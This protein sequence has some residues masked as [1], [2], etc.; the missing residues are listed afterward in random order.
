MRLVNVRILSSWGCCAHLRWTL[1][2]GKPLRCLTFKVPRLEVALRA[3]TAF[4]CALWCMINVS[5]SSSGRVF[6]QRGSIF[7]SNSKTSRS[8]EFGK[9]NLHI[10]NSSLQNTAKFL[11]R[12]R[13]IFGTFENILIFSPRNFDKYFEG[14]LFGYVFLQHQL[15][16][17]QEIFFSEFQNFYKEGFEFGKEN[18]HWNL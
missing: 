10:P 14:S 8:F 5:I 15:L 3:R 16:V 17:I 18:L 11:W 7:F 2:N 1:R 12:F 6:P 4:R 13:Y 9:G